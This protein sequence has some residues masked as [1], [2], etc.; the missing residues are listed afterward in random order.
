MQTP[1][2]SLQNDKKIDK[3]KLIQEITTEDQI[4]TAE[5]F[6]KPI[7]SEELEA[8]GAEIAEELTAS[9]KAKRKTKLSLLEQVADYYND[10]NWK[11]Y[12]TAKNLKGPKEILEAKQIVLKDLDN[13]RQKAY[14]NKDNESLRA[15]ALIETELEKGIGHA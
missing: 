6:A 3:Q 9:E 7:E 15:I 1:E 5:K 14:A 8:L 2:Q 11:E 12:E 10:E 13:L 4:K